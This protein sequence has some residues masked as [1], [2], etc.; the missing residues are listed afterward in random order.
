M[1]LVSKNYKRK[2][3]IHCVQYECGYQK[4]TESA[5]LQARLVHTS[6]E[7]VFCWNKDE[8]KNITYDIESERIKLTYCL[9]SDTN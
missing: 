7:G 8:R 1:F 2:S 3:W 4:L 6:S 9:V 5:S